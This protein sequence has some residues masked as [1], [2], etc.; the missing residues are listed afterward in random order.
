M[1]T[2]FFGLE[3]LYSAMLSS[4]AVRLKEM[5]RVICDD[6]AN[7][8]DTLANGM[9]KGLLLTISTALAHSLS[10]TVGIRSDYLVIPIGLVI[11]H[12]FKSGLHNYCA[13]YIP[14]S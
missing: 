10:Y 3:E 1:E 7:D 14:E 6:I 11:D 2:M 12:A 4:D 5:D 8:K 9:M 13:N